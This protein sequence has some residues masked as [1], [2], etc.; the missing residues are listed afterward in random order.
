MESS[1]MKRIKHHLTGGNL[2]LYMLSLLKKGKRHAYSLDGEI[3]REF[4]F[5]PNR[6]MVYIVLYKLEAEGM[7][8]SEFEGR[9]KY[10]KITEKG[11]E[12]IREAK[13]YLKKLSG[14]L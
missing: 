1:P 2:W 5:K 6:I 4:A 11:K 12:N 13:Y 14:R 3:S 9:R 8:S 10:Y 7:I